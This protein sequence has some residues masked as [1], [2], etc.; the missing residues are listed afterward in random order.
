MKNFCVSFR[1]AGILLVSANPSLVSGKTLLP[2]CGQA[3]ILATGVGS[4]SSD[5][6]RTI[7]IQIKETTLSLTPYDSSSK[8]GNHESDADITEE[9]SQSLES[10]PKLQIHTN[11]IEFESVAIGN[12][13]S[14]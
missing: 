3:I 8:L 9:D 7:Y 10:V 13:A 11:P 14:K 5:N 1:S 4:E 6:S 12:S 2:W